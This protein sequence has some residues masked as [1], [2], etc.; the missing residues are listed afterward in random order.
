M[1]MATA[2]RFIPREQILM[3][4]S[5]PTR[6]TVTAET[7]SEPEPE[8]VTADPPEPTPDETDHNDET[9]T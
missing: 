2:T 4:E 7:D 1:V 6:G 9:G 8:A 3:L 5:D